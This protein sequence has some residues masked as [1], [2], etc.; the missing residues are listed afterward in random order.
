MGTTL[1]AIKRVTEVKDKRQD[2]FYKM[3][4]R[5]HKD[6]QKEEIRATIRDGIEVIAPAAANRE[7]AISVATRSSLRQKVQQ[8]ME[9]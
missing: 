6:K 9:V 2:S 4:M 5:A 3:R 7:K 8:K 1:R